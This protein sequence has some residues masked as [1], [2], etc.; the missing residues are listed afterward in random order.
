V[1]YDLGKLIVEEYMHNAELM[2]PNKVNEVI[3]QEIKTMFI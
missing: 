2:T 1:A 3:K